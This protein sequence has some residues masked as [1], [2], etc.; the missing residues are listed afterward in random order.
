MLHWL[1]LLLLVPPALR[2]AFAFF[3]PQVL[4]DAESKGVRMMLQHHFGAPSTDPLVSE[5]GHR[6][7]QG[8]GLKARFFV[9]DGPMINAVTLP[10]GDILL[11]RGLLG[12][13]REHPERL[14]GVLAHELGHL[15]REHYLGR[16]Y[17][18]ALIQ[19]AFGFLAR[20]FVVIFMRQ[21]VFRILGFGFSRAFEH[22]AD[23]T[24]VDLLV[25]AGID[26]NGLAAL[27]DDLAGIVE[28]MGM[29]GT[30]PDPSYRAMRVRAKIEKLGLLQD[31]EWSR[32][33][34]E[35]RTREPDA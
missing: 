35:F 3:Y 27:F 16:I 28:P 20:P 34:L 8:T 5:I 33:V 10:D 26:P 9:I 11:W 19:F 6:L 24:A 23:D 32:K 25:A 22:Q 13:V 15:K 21:I 18:L 12:R 7:L 17:W 14:A 30:H 1:F 29:L 4:K 31:T 2:L